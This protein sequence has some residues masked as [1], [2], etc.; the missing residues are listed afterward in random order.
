MLMA[1]ALVWLPLPE[2]TEM[3]SRAQDVAIYLSHH[4]HHAWDAFGF[5]DL[6]RL[7]YLA[8]GWHIA[9]G[10]GLLFD[11]TITAHRSA[12]LSGAVKGL[13]P[14][15][16]MLPSPELHP[17]DEDFLDSFCLTYGVATREAVKRQVDRED[18][19][20]RLTLLVGGEGAVVRPELMQATF[21]LMLL[22]HAETSRK[23]RES[24]IGT[25]M[26]RATAENVV[27]FRPR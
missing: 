14:L 22:D 4:F 6:Q 18:G 27:A 15:E 12:P 19:A 2:G 10:R 11:G 26:Q 1:A 7:M 9:S 25:Q 5:F 8:Q 21:R 3:A 13:V 23:M 24:Q 20:W 17:Y 16:E